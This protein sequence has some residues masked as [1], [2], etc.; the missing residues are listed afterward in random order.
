[1]R[2]ILSGVYLI[3]NNY[4]RNQKKK[5]PVQDY[6]TNYWKRRQSEIRGYQRTLYMNTDDRDYLRVDYNL[7]EKRVRLYVEIAR[8][9]GS[10]YYA[11]ISNGRLTTERNATTGRAI[12]VNEKISQRADIFSTIPNNEILKLINGYYGIQSKRANRDKSEKDKLKEE[13]RKRYF[14]GSD[15]AYEGSGADQ[16]FATVK[17]FD[18]F[19]VIIGCCAGAFVYWFF[20]YSMVMA[21]VVLAFYGM[22]IGLI[23]MFLRERPPL[24]SKM[25]AFIVAGI[26]LYVYGYFYW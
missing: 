25:I 2:R 1:M 23:D 21:G 7:K 17:W 26:S 14:Q 19:D 6:S 5:T 11:V 18:F 22:I 4:M 24:F 9:G 16:T 10:S 20:N 3:I 13:A 8:E 15:I 12:G